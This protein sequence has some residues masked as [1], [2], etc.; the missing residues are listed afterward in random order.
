MSESF[1]GAHSGIGAPIEALSDKVNK[2]LILVAKNLD[3]VLCC[4]SS[5]LTSLVWYK[6]RYTIVLEELLP[7][8]ACLQDILAWSSAY[9]HHHGKLFHF[10]F[11]GEEWKANAELSHYAAK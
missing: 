4:R 3:E 9:L 5:H 11:A 2:R 7:S 10:V 8:S 1:I 6:N